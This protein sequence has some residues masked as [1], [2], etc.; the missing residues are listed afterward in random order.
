MVLNLGAIAVV[1]CLLAGCGSSGTSMSKNMGARAV[2]FADTI[3]REYNSSIYTERVLEDKGGQGPRPGQF[4]AD[5]EAEFT[6]LRAVMDSA[7]EIS[8]VRVYI[9]D[10]TVQDRFLTA[11]SKEVGKGYAAY[12]HFALSR[13][14]RYGAHRSEVKVADD[15]KALGLTPCIGPRPRKP[16]EG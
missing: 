12:L 15:A 3:C 14:F 2:A 5:R 4:L 10:L 7:R 1:G 11:L 13:S 9:S 16:I 6:K 8:R